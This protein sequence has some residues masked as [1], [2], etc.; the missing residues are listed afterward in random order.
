M[1]LTLRSIHFFILILAFLVCLIL[2]HYSPLQFNPHSIQTEEASW[3]DMNASDEHYFHD[4]NGDNVSEFIRVK[5]SPRGITHESAYVLYTSNVDKQQLD[6][7]EQWLIGSTFFGDYNKDKRDEIYSFT[8]VNDSLF[9]YAAVLNAELEFFIKRQLILVRTEEDRVNDLSWD[10]RVGPGQMIDVDEDGFPDLLFTVVAGRSLKPRKVFVFSIKK[11]QIVAMT[12]HMAAHLSHTWVMDWNGDNQDEVIIRT[13]AT[14]NYPITA[15][16]SDAYNW[17]FVFD[18]KLKR[19]LYSHQAPDPRQ[20]YELPFRWQHNS[21]LIEIIQSERSSN[22]PHI[23]VYDSQFQRIADTTLTVSHQDQKIIPFFISRHELS[24]EENNDRFM[25]LFPG[26]KIV[27]LDP[28][29]KVKA[30]H[31]FPFDV[32]GVSPLYQDLDLDGRPEIILTA[33]N[34]IF[35]MADDL[36]EINQVYLSGYEQIKHTTLRKTG[37]AK[38]VQIAVQ[39]PG[40]V[41]LLNYGAN[42]GYPLRFLLFP[43]LFIVVWV[44]LSALFFIYRKKHTASHWMQFAMKSTSHGLLLLEAN[45]QI[46]GAN[47]GISDA[48]GVREHI[49]RGQN[50]F[51][52][53]SHH[54]VFIQGLTK[55]LTGGKQGNGNFLVHDKNGYTHT[56]FEIL[57]IFGFF[58]I[59]LGYFVE[60]TNLDKMLSD[61]RLQSW[62]ENVRKMAHDIKSPL[63]SIYLNLETLKAKIRDQAPIVNKEIEPELQLMSSELSRLRGMSKNF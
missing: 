50:V 26:E 16:Y 57:P 30:E 20:S 22:L 53:F 5:Y 58:K 13:S 51:Q 19:M 60:V 62:S 52:V 34:R 38:P 61:E 41:M 23:L 40:Q 54:P 48:L 47:A 37:T 18:K 15:P 46:R 24:G 44:S 45:G 42:P 14:A 49:Q 21:F 59:P 25:L 32:N 43:C 9:L 33:R 35:I 17:I 28:Y 56:H 55:A 8:L 1:R 36:S 12:S 6:F 3:M 2:Y 31:P 4:L 63:G 7:S 29:L 10:L 27:E 11:R 39:L